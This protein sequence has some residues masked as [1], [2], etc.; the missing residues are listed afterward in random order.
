MGLEDVD[1]LD[2]FAPMKFNYFT[3][4]A[5]KNYSRMGEAILDFFQFCIYPTIFSC[6]LE[7]RCAYVEDGSGCRRYCV[8]F[9]VSC[10]SV[11]SEEIMEILK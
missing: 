5:W 3:S 1:N 4:L 7:L 11:L 8:R 10:V 6:G 9:M 2:W